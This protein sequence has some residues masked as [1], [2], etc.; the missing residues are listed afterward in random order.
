MRLF[1]PLAADATKYTAYNLYERAKGSMAQSGQI[2]WK[3]LF[4]GKQETIKLP[5][6]YAARDQTRLFYN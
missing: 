1:V 5:G 4:G 3:W 2:Q 6:E